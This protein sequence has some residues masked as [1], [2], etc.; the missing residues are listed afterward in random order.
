MEIAFANNEGGCLWCYA[1]VPLEIDWCLM[2][3][4]IL[5]WRKGQI[6]CEFISLILRQFY[7]LKSWLTFLIK[8]YNFEK[9]IFFENNIKRIFSWVCHGFQISLYVTNFQRTNC[10]LLYCIRSNSKIYILKATFRCIVTC[11]TH[12]FNA[13]SS[14][15][16]QLLSQVISHQNFWFK[17]RQKMH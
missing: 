8:K 3:I 4:Y 6:N 15:F 17:N 14:F 13:F 7:D 9:R 16:C 12:Q 5:K 2:E 1:C 10:H 11:N